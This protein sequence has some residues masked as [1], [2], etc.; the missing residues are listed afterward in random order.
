M[1]RTAESVAETTKLRWPPK[2]NVLGV[3]VSATTYDEAIDLV[4]EAA[5][6]RQSAVVSHFAVHAVVSAA[7]DPGL[8]KQVRTFEMITPD[9]QPVR[10]ALN[11]L[12]KTRL[13]DRVYGPEMMVRLC[14]RAADEG[15]LIYFYGSTVD[16]LEKLEQNLTAQFPALR[17]AGKESPPFRQLTT[18]EEE[19]MIERINGSGAGIVFIG[20]GCPKQDRFAYQYRHRLHA[21][22]ICAGAAFDFHA[23]TKAIAPAWMQKCGL[24]WLFRL[25]QEPKRL[26]KRYLVTNTIFVKKLFAQFVRQRV[27]RRPA[28]TE[29]ELAVCSEPS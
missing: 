13:T 19:A 20:L 16:V 2:Y 14:R 22:Q 29:A 4:I 12:Y 3:G 27:L 11:R 26:W 17:V 9:G 10:W 21:V 25:S 24:E 7:I 5:R 15:V 1:I 6:R 28:E 8:L 18:E 23:G